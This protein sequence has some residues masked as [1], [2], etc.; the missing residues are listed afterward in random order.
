MEANELKKVLN[1]LKS[2]ER[3][4]EAEQED[5]IVYSMLEHIGST[6]GDSKGSTNLQHVLSINNRK[7]IT[8]A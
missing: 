5:V 7:E 3:T 1:E 4:W 8:R 6:D 2:G